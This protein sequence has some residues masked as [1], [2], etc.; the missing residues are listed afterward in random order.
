MGLTIVSPQTRTYLFM[1]LEKSQY[2]KFLLNPHAYT[3]MVH[4]NFGSK[5]WHQFQ[6]GKIDSS[7][8]VTIC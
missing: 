3:D 7:L 2:R 1:C 6:N 8:Q 5:V 4:C